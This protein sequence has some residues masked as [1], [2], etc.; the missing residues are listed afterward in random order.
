MN[1]QSQCKQAS[2]YLQ[3][4]EKRI[5]H[6]DVLRVIDE[7]V[8]FSFINELAKPYYSN[9]GPNGYS[10]ERLFR[11]LIVMYMENISSERR[12]VNE[13][14]V[15]LRYLWFTKTDLDTP[16]P[17]HST[18][19]VL[20]SRLGD[21]LFKQIF[22]RI[23][24]EVITLGI[25]HPTSISVDSTSVLADVK[26]PAKGD[27]DVTI[28]GKQIISP[29]DPDAR[30]GHTSPKE[31]FFG[32]KAQIMV[33]NK[34]Q[35]I[36][37]IDAKPGSFEDYHLEGS[38]VKEPMADNGLKPH[39]AALDR[40]FDS[41]GVRRLFKEQKI[42]TAIPIRLTKPDKSDLY[43]KDAF[44]IDL[45]HKKV[46]CPANKRLQ[47]KGFDAA[48]LSHEFIGTECTSCQLRSNCTTAVYRRLTVHRDYLL[49]QKAIRFN[50]TKAYKA[51]FRKRTAVERVI[52][53]AKRFHGMVRAKFRSLWKLKIQVYLTAIAINLKRIAKFFIEQ[54]N[55]S[56]ITL[57]AGP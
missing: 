40:G 29:H 55:F 34:S 30:Y 36:L 56:A 37:N 19:S 54:P 16:V 23:V 48:R 21:A 8:D 46:T 1:W 6:D 5:P 32:Y 2:F 38:F 51:I 3:Q 33:D 26:L 39:E 20:R 9:L 43:K 14:N 7:K 15:N 45:R 44:K 18:F 41:Y 28:D 22:T 52:A 27:K 11:M 10:P 35:A 42:K 17:D 50:K 25:A 24:S 31:S 53:E 57:R 49:R 4:M 13:L 12:L 47:Y